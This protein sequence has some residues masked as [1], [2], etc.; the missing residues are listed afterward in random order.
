MSFNHISGDFSNRLCAVDSDVLLRRK[1]C[2]G[3][4]GVPAISV[5]DGQVEVRGGGGAEAET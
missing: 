2:P 1:A 4:R 3:S 5:N